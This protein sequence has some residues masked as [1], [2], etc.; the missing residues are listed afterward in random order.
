MYAFRHI[1]NQLKAKLSASPTLARVVPFLIFIT[2]TFCQGQFGEAGRYWLYLGKTIVGVW[3]V[4]GLMRPLVAEMKWVFSWEAVVVGVAVLL[5]WVGLDGYYPTMAELTERYLNPIF[6]A[7]GL[8]SWATPAK[9]NLPWNPQVQF[10]HDSPLAWLFIVGRIL[11]SSIIV[12]PLEEVFY[13]SFIYRYIIRPDFQAVS[14]GVFKLSAFAFTALL[15]GFSHYEWL[16]GILCAFA[17]QGLVCWKKRLGDA[18]TAHAITNCL[19]G[20]YIV[21]QDAW[22]FW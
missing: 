3:L 22:H 19:L 16:A 21:W 6:R 2:F 12:P 20:L 1:L 8:S 18:M 10:G 11:G 9:A 14:L 7:I 17:Y 4:W 15:F 5:M 13:R